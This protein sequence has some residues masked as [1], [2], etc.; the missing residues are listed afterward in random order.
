VLHIEATSLELDPLALGRS[1]EL[2][3]GAPVE[4]LGGTDEPERALVDQVEQG[5]LGAL[6]ALGD[7]HHEPQVVGDQLLL[8]RQVTR[9]I[10]SA[11]ETSSAALSSR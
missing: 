7:R 11:S 4:L 5:Q 1:A 2:D 9:S 10:R 6:V 8:G 3:V